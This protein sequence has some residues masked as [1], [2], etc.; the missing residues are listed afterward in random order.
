MIL[1]FIENKEH[2]THHYQ[3]SNFDITRK[4]NIKT[5]QI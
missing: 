5:I 2:K 4:H 1:I 3:A